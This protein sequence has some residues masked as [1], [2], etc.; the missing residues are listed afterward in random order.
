M[1]V[2]ASFT[3][4]FHYAYTTNIIMSLSPLFFSL[5]LSLSLSP[6]AAQPVRSRDDVGED[7]YLPIIGSG[8]SESSVLTMDRPK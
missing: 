2:C 5:S 4:H 7:T 6:V 3:L 1:N 8:P